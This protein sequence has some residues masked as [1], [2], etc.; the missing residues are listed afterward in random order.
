MR[1]LPRRLLKMVASF[2]ALHLSLWAG[3][4]PTR[5][6]VDLSPTP[7]TVMLSAFDLSIVEADAKV[8]L[9]AQQTLGNK[10]LARVNVFELPPRSRAIDIA[11]KIGV[12][13]L[14]ATQAGWT[15]LD[16]THPNWVPL[17]V[18]EMVQHAAEQGFDGFVLTGL[19]TI[20]Q[21]AERAACLKAIQELD[22]IY[23]DKQ[24]I[25]ENGLDLVA[26]GRR[27]LDGVLFIGRAENPAVR[28]QRIREVKRH[29]LQPLVVE[30]LPETV[31]DEEIAR[32]TEHFRA[33]GAVPFFTTPD[34]QGTHL[35]PLVEVTRHVVV[36]HSGAASETFTAHVLQG[37][38]EWLGW[39]VSYVDAGKMQQPEQVQEWQQADAL[40]LDA[41]LQAQP[42]QQGFLLD[43]VRALKERRAPL[44]LTGA[45]WGNDA[46]F[47]QWS[48]TLGLRGNGRALP[49]TGKA[50][51]KP[52]ASP[53]LH[54]AGSMRARTLGFRDL[55]APAGA[56]V[57]SA[58]EADGILFDQVFITS[59]GGV[60]LDA[61]AKEAGPQI[62][63][64]PFLE[65]WLGRY[66]RVPVMDV[67][68][69]NG[70]RLLIPVVDSEGFT[71]STTLQG[72]PLAA[73]ALTERL[74][75]RYSLPFTVAVCEGDLRGTNPGLDPRDTLRYEAAARA[76]FS[77]PQVHAA[78]GSLSR[79]SSWETCPEME[80]EVAGT[81]AYVHRRLLPAGRHV[82][83]MLWPQGARPTDE[84]VA[85]SHRMGVENAWITATT[86][87]PGTSPAK[88]AQTWG[89]HQSL[90]TL[91]PLPHQGALRA[92]EF[93]AHEEAQNAS[94][95]MQPVN[96]IFSFRDAATEER[97]WE[98]ENI[99]DWCASQPLHAITL[100]EHAKI[101]R[102]AARTRLFEQGPG[103]WILV[104]AGQARTLRLPV[105]A[106]IP[107][108]DRS[109]GLAGYS[110]RGPDLYIHT[111]GRRRTE[112]VLTPQGTPTH[113]R[114][115][116]AS[117]KLRYDEAG[118]QR[119]LIQVADLRPVELSFAGIAPGSVCQVFTTDHP[120]F[121]TADSRG[122][123][124]VTV[125]AQSAV[126]VQVLNSPQAAMR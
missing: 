29:G 72:L 113:L 34:L 118:Q 40:I 88:M 18:R 111:L 2:L 11:K 21:D 16:A 47:S 43:A 100:A 116:S 13:T 38:L 78:A 5:L 119:A 17:V 70:R 99:L 85:F 94:R 91:T 65:H 59:W 14:E 120:Q 115:T 122:Q 64:L 110:V 60:W 73:E 57:L 4:N 46:D 3:V 126:R 12:P 97:L 32:H 19:E 1:C 102:D 35:G 9:E 83:L 33:M 96:A 36:I 42:Q 50:S 7:D 52:I 76:I 105:S 108:L 41:N 44:L 98:A 82:D 90:L 95:W 25:L 61:M 26:E 45:P 81:M 66:S 123:I 121:L 101:V 27:F 56:S 24:L 124:E 74:L 15:R 112:L 22:R 6:M 51:I 10:V 69:Q 107:D 8:D 77:L 93:I 62:A 79:P 109:V 63:P 30:S 71:Q 86:T 103:H 23:P 92:A 37:S 55:R 54:Q 125:P 106:G 80:R 117:G 39:Q 48:Q 28:D 20:S 84:A 68:S 67:A 58:I 87:L 104:N 75:S 89:Q 31:T 49:V 53:W 114:L